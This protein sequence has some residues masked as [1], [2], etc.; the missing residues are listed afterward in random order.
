MFVFRNRSLRDGESGFSCAVALCVVLV[1]VLI[2]SG[3]LCGL[4]GGR[5]CV[6]IH[7]SEFKTIM[8]SPASALVSNS[9]PPWEGCVLNM[10]DVKRVWTPVS[11]SDTLP[12]N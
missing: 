1:L 9:I 3:F 12:L 6:G 10:E 2:V 4:W 11:A 8:V 7:N 5:Q